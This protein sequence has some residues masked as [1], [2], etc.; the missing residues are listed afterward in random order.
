MTKRKKGESQ[1]PVIVC[2]APRAGTTLLTKMLSACGLWPGHTVNDAWENWWFVNINEYLAAHSGCTWDQP[3]TEWTITPTRAKESAKEKVK[4]T[5]MYP[6]DVPWCWKDPGR[7]DIFLDF[8][9]DVFPEAEAIRIVR[10]PMDVAVSLNRRERNKPIELLTRNQRNTSLEGNGVSVVPGKSR[11]A[12]SMEGALDIALEYYRLER[13]YDAEVR[14]EDLVASPTE[15][16]RGRLDAV[17]NLIKNSREDLLNN[18]VDE[19]RAFA[20]K[21]DPEL[22]EWWNEHKP[23]GFSY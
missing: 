19:S 22:Q 23:K 5:D 13:P 14:F 1:P 6:A 9:K 2:G 20:F 21:D 15:A 7:N 10:H 4:E 3:P 12:M 8:W 16:I 18:L 17:P 11:R